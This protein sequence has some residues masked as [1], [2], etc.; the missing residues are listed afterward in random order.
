MTRNQQIIRKAVISLYAEPRTAWEVAYAINY[1]YGLTFDCAQRLTASKVERIW[2]EE[3]EHNT[4][5]R[6]LGERPAKG[7]P[8]SD[9]VKLAKRLLAA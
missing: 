1:H 6:N 4:V 3:R 8:P 7:F 5:M 9:V 2:N